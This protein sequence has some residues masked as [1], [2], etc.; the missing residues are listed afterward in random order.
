MNAAE[1]IPSI[2]NATEHKLSPRT[3]PEIDC[4]KGPKDQWAADGRHPIGE[5]GKGY[6]LGNKNI[7]DV[8]K[9]F[10]YESAGHRFG[11][12]YEWV[13]K[14]Y[15]FK[16]AWKTFPIPFVPVTI[17]VHNHAKPGQIDAK[18]CTE[19]TTKLISECVAKGGPSK[20][21]HF[22]GGYLKH[23]GWG[24]ILF[25]DADYCYKKVK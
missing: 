17:Q 10:C 11:K 20:L 13:G 9:K 14:E 3:P 12:G 22:R 5:V 2:F 4:Y 16:N 1:T 15:W 24:Y 6:D 7:Y 8:A 19:M 21:D 18:H 25:C 23:N